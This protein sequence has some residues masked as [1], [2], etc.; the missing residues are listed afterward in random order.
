MVDPPHAAHPH[1]GW[2][3]VRAPTAERSGRRRSTAARTV[4]VCRIGPWVGIRHD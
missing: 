4:G 1:P 3:A 2:R